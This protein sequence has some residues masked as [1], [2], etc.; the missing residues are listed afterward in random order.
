MPKYKV[1]YFQNDDG[2]GVAAAA[3]PAVQPDQPQPPDHHQEVYPLQAARQ[4]ACHFRCS[5]PA[6]KQH[7]VQTG[8]D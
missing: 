6:G 4:E 2:G 3:V 8:R 7:T 5:H 1:I